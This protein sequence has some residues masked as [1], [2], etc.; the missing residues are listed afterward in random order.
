MDNSL[1][2]IK[3]TKKES[4]MILS[5][6]HAIKN[7]SE[8]KLQELQNQVRLFNYCKRGLEDDIE[9]I[10][11]IL[12]ND[13]IRNI[14]DENYKEKYLVNKFNQEG[15]TVLFHS[16][17]NGHLKI[18]ELLI[19]FGAD[20][21]IKFE[22]Q[23]VLDLSIRWGHVKLVE[24]LLSLNWPYEYLKEGLK[25]AVK[26]KNNIMIGLIRKAIADEKIRNKHKNKFSCCFG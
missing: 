4:N 21:L 10:K 6:K 23:S 14:Y 2:N 8:E 13:P 16:C 9:K 22:D 1:K 5:E 25:L 19:K 20:Y 24:Y 7:I 11:E 26:G 15:L 18:T 3:T 12:K 17:M